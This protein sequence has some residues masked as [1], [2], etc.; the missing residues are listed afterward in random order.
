VLSFIGSLPFLAGFSPRSFDFLI[1]ALGFTAAGV[2]MEIP[3]VTLD[4]AAARMQ[5]HR[6]E[7]EKAWRDY[8]GISQIVRIVHQHRRSGRWWNQMGIRRTLK[9]ASS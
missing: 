1:E 9:P 6:V 5:H 7:L 4:D 2:T 3:I 8:Y